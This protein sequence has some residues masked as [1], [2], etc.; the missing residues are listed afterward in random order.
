MLDST[1]VFW[2]N[3]KEQQRDREFLIWSSTD[4]FANFFLWCTS[5]SLIILWPAVWSVFVHHNVKWLGLE[6]DTPDYCQKKNICFATLGVWS[7]N[8]PHKSPWRWSRTRTY[9]GGITHL[10]W[11]RLGIPQEVHAG[12]KEIW[13]AST[14]FLW[15]GFK[16]K[17]VHRFKYIH[18]CCFSDINRS[19][20][21]KGK[22]YLYLNHNVMKLSEYNILC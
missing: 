6:S 21:D 4:W 9:A 3:L 14:W 20:F 22:M 7:E 11:K 12:S 17:D 5:V 19:T 13:S 16:T 18:T 2:Y 10:S 8:H 1:N 15:P